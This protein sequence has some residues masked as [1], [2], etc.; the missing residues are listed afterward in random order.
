MRSPVLG[1]GYQCPRPGSSSCVTMSKSP[2]SSEPLE[3]G[4][5]KRQTPEPDPW[6]GA[7]EVMG[8]QNLPGLW[9]LSGKARITAVSEGDSA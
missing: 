9:C 5:V 1:E 2:T 3:Q 6:F 8:M 4:A 7:Q